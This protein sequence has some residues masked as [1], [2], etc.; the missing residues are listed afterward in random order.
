MATM[1]CS[2]GNTYCRKY[3]SSYARTL[4]TSHNRIE[5]LGMAHMILSMPVPTI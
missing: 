3:S 4:S 1:I 2:C 5:R